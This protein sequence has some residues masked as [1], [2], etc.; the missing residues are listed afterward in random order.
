[1]TFIVGLAVGAL[2]VRGYQRLHEKRTAEVFSW[3]L[4]CSEL[5]NQYARNES[6]DTQS[7]GVEAVA[8]SGAS[9]SCVASFKIW[10]QISSRD[11]VQEW[12]VMDLLS[13]G[14]LYT[15]YCRKELDCGG[16]ND[17]K[18]DRRSEAA[19]RQ[20]VKGQEIDVGKIN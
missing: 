6:N 7:V 11:T 18:L 8:Y 10:E 20:A 16:G 13:A 4:R 12:R 9:N 5:A 19:F 1:M 15:A 17:V 2:G 3:R 14:R